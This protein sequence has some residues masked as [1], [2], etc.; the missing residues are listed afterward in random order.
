MGFGKKSGPQYTDLDNPFLHMTHPP[1]PPPPSSQVTA[2]QRSP[3]YSLPA[4]FFW[5][6]SFSMGVLRLVG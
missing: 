3:R 1:S 2:S 6:F 5:E 4:L